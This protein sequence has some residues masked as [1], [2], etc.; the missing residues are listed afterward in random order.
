MSSSKPLSPIESGPPQPIRLGLLPSAKVVDAR[1]LGKIRISAQ[2]ACT[3]LNAA[4]GLL[5]RPIELIEAAPTLGLEAATRHLTEVL[6]CDALI[7]N[8]S[9]SVAPSRPRIALDHGATL[10]EA[11]QEVFRFTPLPVH[12]VT[13][14]L[15]R[16]ARI[17]GPKFFIAGGRDAWSCGT[18]EAASRALEAIGGELVSTEHLD[19]DGVQMETLLDHVE[20]SGVD[21]F[22]PCFDRKDLPALLTRFTRRG[23]KRRI[24]VLA[25]RL[26]ESVAA[27]LAPEVREGVFAC[28][29]YFTCLDNPAN[30][31]YLAALGN[32]LGDTETPLPPVAK[33]GASTYLCV[34]GFARAAEQAG[35]LEPSALISALER[36][37]LDGPQGP[38]RMDPVSHRVRLATHLARCRF[39]GTFSIIQSFDPI[40][41][42]ASA[43]EPTDQQPLAPAQDQ[44]APPQGANNM[45]EFAVIGIDAD[46]RIAF[47]NRAASR[48]WGF[49]ERHTL[50]G[51]PVE[52]LWQS[53]EAFAEFMTRHQHHTE[54]QDALTARLADGTPKRLRVIGE[55][56]PHLH[57]ERPGYI[58]SC[59]DTHAVRLQ[60]TIASYECLAMADIA[61]IATDSSGTIIE[62]NHRA[63]DLFGYAGGALLGLSIHELVP[64]Q[65][66]RRHA[67]NIRRFQAEADNERRMGMRTEV[68]GYRGDG[69][70]FP[71]EVAISRFDADGDTILVAALRDITDRKTAETELV[72]R[73][74]HDA[75]TGLPNRDLMQERLAHA[76]ARS[77]KQGHAVALLFIDLDGFKLINDTHGHSVGDALLQGIATRL[78]EHVRP[79]DTVGRLGGDEFVVLCDQVDDSVSIVSL[80]ERLND[81]LREPLDL[82]G[83]QL[84]A[85]ASIGLAI[86][87]GRTHC[88]EELLRNADTAMYSAKE[89][90]RDGWRFFSEEIHEQARKRLDISNGLRQ[91]I[92][93]AELE[94][95]FQPIL[96]TES[97]IIRGAEVLLRWMPPTGEIPPSLFIPIAEMSGSIVPIGKWVFQAA[98]EA[99][100]DWFARFGEQAPYVSV[101][102]SARQL[103]DESVV[104]AFSEILRDTGADPSRLLL[105][106]TETSL[107]SDVTSN[108]RLLH[109]LADLGLRVAVDDFG[110]GYS[111]LAQLLRM[112]VNFL[113][114]DREFVDGLDKRH[115]SKAIVS[116]V[117]SMARAMQLQVVAEGVENETQHGYLRDIGCDYVQG[118][119]FHRPLPPSEFLSLLLESDAQERKAM[120]EDLHAVLYVS[121]ATQ[122]MSQDALMDLLGFARETNRAQGITGFLLY[123]NGSFMQMIEGSYP[124]IQRLMERIEADPRHRNVTR[125]YEGRIDKRIFSDWSMGFRN[126]D[127]LDQGFD[128]RGW[129]ARTMNFL[130]MSE[131]VHVCYNLICAFAA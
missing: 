113:K 119:F 127:H 65:A 101:N 90:G 85:T 108:L 116:A 53:A 58:L 118:Y 12:N 75:L 37:E 39:D 57:A 86:G 82:Q 16:M 11:S 78:V 77:K 55:I 5:G 34:R 48:L 106:L 70:L 9:T 21:V 72:W 97:Q 29:S 33:V 41:E 28:G 111:S 87:H 95:R 6:G 64:P 59:V 131:D 73:A 74:S 121:L 100:R 4:G 62:T 123:L 20:R 103:N 92:Q 15:E 26:D 84:F 83:R 25:S 40:P 7:G 47:V 110:T 120:P 80:A 91:A 107:M 27:R 45:P 93:N 18:T 8:P 54:W 67:D 96:C 32:Q 112:P 30:R 51:V 126:M 36:L 52:T 1:Q 49:D 66:R 130:D 117:C 104:E 13:P 115:D 128:Y 35:S 63:N 10:D 68:H 88:A 79:G 102:I 109:R 24:A 124:R 81:A 23:L 71:V 14:V 105:E 89:Q 76:L 43:S 122:P 42:P 50:H 46:G 22:L 17:A 2:A 99:E 60:Q 31:A 61:V 125:L 94:I 69:S 98:C 38:V 56:S 3:E 129:R 114:I 19:L 44:T